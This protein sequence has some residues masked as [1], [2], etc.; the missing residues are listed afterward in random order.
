MG[1][2]AWGWWAGTLCTGQEPSGLAGEAQPA[3]TPVPP[4]SRGGGHRGLSNWRAFHLFVFA[5]INPSQ[6]PMSVA[7]GSAGGGEGKG[8][9]GP[10]RAEPGGRGALPELCGRQGTLLPLQWGFLRPD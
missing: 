9:A 5:V 1:G 2:V 8:S 10:G 7:L 3:A 4:P 6:R